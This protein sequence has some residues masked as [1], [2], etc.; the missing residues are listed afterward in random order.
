MFRVLLFMLYYSPIPI[1]AAWY[2][3]EW[4]HAG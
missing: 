2:A 4:C 1:I 3:Y